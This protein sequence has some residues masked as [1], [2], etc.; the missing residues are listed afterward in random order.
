[1]STT[2]PM[3]PTPKALVDFFS[4]SLAA[5]QSS[6]DAFRVLCTLPHRQA[7]PAPR[8]VASPLN[9]LVVL[10]SSFNPPTTA[11]ASMAQEALEAIDGG[12]SPRLVLLLAVNNADKAH[13]PASFPVRLGMMEAFGRELL[14]QA[15]TR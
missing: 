15:S 14:E 6:P 8:R 2:S 4:R 3:R 13:K 12:V 9:N 1:M 7:T 5:F 10:D 11:H